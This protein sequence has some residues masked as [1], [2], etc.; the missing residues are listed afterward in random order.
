MEDL[1]TLHLVLERLSSLFRARLRE[2]AAAHGL[3]LVQLEALIYLSMAN[4]YSDTPS[5]LAD[6]LGVTKGTAGQTVA[7]LERHG[8]VERQVDGEDGRVFH[9]GP[10][11]AGRRVVRSA[12]PAAFLTELDRPNLRDAANAGVELLRAIQAVHDFRSFGQC[13]TCAHFQRDGARFR[14]GLTSERLT[15]TDA[16]RI[17]REHARPD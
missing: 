3:K 17:C 8:F 11:D 2:S 14:C 5:A 13:Q 10:T 9:C 12:Y 15:R 1:Q 4:R 7:A 6:Y 16:L